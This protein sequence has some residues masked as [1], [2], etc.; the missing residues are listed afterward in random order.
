MPTSDD[1]IQRVLGK[2]LP[3]EMKGKIP[4]IM[5]LLQQYDLSEPS[6][7]KNVEQYL[8]TMGIP[9]DAIKAISGV[10]QERGAEQKAKAD[11]DAAS[12]YDFNADTP[13][14][15]L[16]AAGGKQFAPDLG[17][18]SGMSDD[19][20][21]K[22]IADSQAPGQPG[23]PAAPAAPEAPPTVAEE[24]DAKY[25]N[26]MAWLED[27]FEQKGPTREEGLKLG[28]TGDTAARD[29]QLRAADELF[30]LY[31]QGGRGA[32]DR[33]ARAEARASSEDWL[34]G[35]RDAD[36][37]N[38]SERGMSGSGA[39]LATM[40]GDRQQAA[41]RLSA[42]DLSASASA[43]QRALDALMGGNAVSSDVRK[44][45]D[46]YVSGNMKMLA[47][48]EGQNVAGRRKA[49]EALLDRR[50][51]F[52]MGKLGLQVGA[53]GQT[54]S[55]DSV[56]QQAGYG[57]SDKTATTDT[58][59]VNKAQGGYNTGRVSTDQAGADRLA[60]QGS[61]VAGAAGGV[62]DAVGQ[63]LDSLEEQTKSYVG[64]VGT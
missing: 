1:Q 53:A 14:E 37:Q 42:A 55:R 28:T 4:D 36:M 31:E 41:S 46:D 39:E 12:K 32:Q 21:A 56:E 40:L 10:A 34:K 25:G 58:G 22:L 35:Q 47:E 23:Q 54:A 49:H 15:V 9:P 64:G 26:D 52:Q 59:A 11:A 60:A 6:A 19:D 38:L 30:G 8:G 48:I 18:F 57:L 16:A 45:A 61:K 43:E 2:S 20:W 17:A 3:D 51:R 50:D 63:G 7:A 62:A 33:A 44:G 29:R 5:S 24:R 27:I 13:D